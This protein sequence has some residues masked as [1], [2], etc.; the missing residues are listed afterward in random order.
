MQLRRRPEELAV[1]R[2]GRLGVLRVEVVG[3]GERHAEGRGDPGPAVGRSEHPDLRNGV[4]P[5]D[6][7]HAAVALAEVAAQLRELI[8]EG[9]GIRAAQRH[10][11]PHVG[12]VRAAEAEVDAMRIQRFE[13][14]EALGHGQG[15]VAREHDPA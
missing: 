8:H 13:H 10:R 9:V 14:P 12:A 7:P 15:S 6:R 4:G 1:E 3:E 2:E 11:G 5:A